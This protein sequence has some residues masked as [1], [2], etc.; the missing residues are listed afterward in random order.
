MVISIDE[1][2][3]EMAR[4]A[5]AGGCFCILSTDTDFVALEAGFAHYLSLG[6]LLDAAAGG[7]AGPAVRAETVRF[8]R[9]AIARALGLRH[10]SELPLLLALVPNGCVPAALLTVSARAGAPYPRISAGLRCKLRASSVSR[11]CQVRRKGRRVGNFSLFLP[12]SFPNFTLYFFL[13]LSVTFLKKIKSK[14][15]QTKIFLPENFDS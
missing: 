5:R 8:D 11:G 1:V 9:D 14:I 7:A 15:F 3:V 6:H 12:F 2:D 4:V 13:F 10:R